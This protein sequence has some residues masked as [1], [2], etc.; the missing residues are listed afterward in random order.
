V[1]INKKRARAD[2]RV[3]EGD[4]VRLPPLRLSASL[5]AA[6]ERLPA[7][8]LP[9]LPV[10]Y[11]DAALLAIDKPAGL[12]AHGGSGVAFGV[13]ETLRRQRPAEKFLELAH[14]LDRETSGVLLIGK[15]RQALI[16]LHDMFRRADDTQAAD[17]R[18]LMLVK[19]AWRDAERVVR[20]P[21][22]KYLTKEG[23]RRVQVDAM[24]G[25]PAHTVFRL[26]ACWQ[27]FS[28]LEGQL[29]TGRTHQLRVHLAHLGYPILGDDKYGDFALN[30]TLQ[31]T[32]L[33]RMALHAWRMEL[34]HPLAEDRRL[35]LV[36][37]LPDAL[38]AFIRYLDGVESREK[39]VVAHAQ[40]CGCL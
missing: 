18:Y 27:R 12:A 32:G 37:P 16:R 33:K 9:L 24:A 11:E 19:G 7:R 25:K 10:L 31:K 20:L 4:D 26:V 3:Q 35:I 39:T 23:E 8:A 17:K 40:R 15:K 21:L 29:Y 1:R 6:P 38:T 2:A 28:L 5:S 14:R 13:I 36:A 34:P 22:L 30:K